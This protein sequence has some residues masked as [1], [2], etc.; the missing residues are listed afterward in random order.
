MEKDHLSI[1]KV[2]KKLQNSSK[3]KALGTCSNSCQ[4]VYCCSPYTKLNSLNYS[5]IK[6]ETEEIKN[7]ELSLFYTFADN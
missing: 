2:F 1:N 3:I 6:G 5:L 4:F 7:F